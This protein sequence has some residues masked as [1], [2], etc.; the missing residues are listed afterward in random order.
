MIQEFSVYSVETDF[1][2]LFSITVPD[3]DL[4]IISDDSWCSAFILL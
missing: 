1:S 2:F 4:N 3:V